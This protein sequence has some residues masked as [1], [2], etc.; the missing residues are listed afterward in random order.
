MCDFIFGQNEYDFWN[1]RQK[2]MLYTCVGDF[3]KI[4]PPPTTGL[5]N[6]IDL[7]LSVV[8]FD[9][10]LVLIRGWYRA[11]MGIE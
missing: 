10:N 7:V 9:L 4:F 2:N 11:L 1:Q 8:L 6:L 5:L 3:L